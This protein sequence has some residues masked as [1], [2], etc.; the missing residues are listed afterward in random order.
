MD[1][2]YSW[3]LNNLKIL[4]FE[5]DEEDRLLTLQNA[6]GNRVDAERSIA[7]KSLSDHDKL[8]QSSTWFR[9]SYFEYTKG[10]GTFNKFRRGI[11]DGYLNIL[12]ITYAEAGKYECM[13]DTAVGRIFGT[14]EVI[15]HG[16]PGYVLL[17]I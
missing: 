3:R 14:S 2:A 16:P 12:N 5:D 6:P 1:L 4:F 13:V 9:G 10:T 17:F 7:Y 15:V 11:L 8:L